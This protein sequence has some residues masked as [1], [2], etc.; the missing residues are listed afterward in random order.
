[1]V[2]RELLQNSGI[3]G[4]I[5]HFFS[6]NFFLS[7]F[8][9]IYIVDF[10]DDA[11]ASSVE[12]IFVTE[13]SKQIGNINLSSKCVRIIFKNNGFVFRSEDWNR[14]KKIAEGNPDEQKVCLH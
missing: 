12:I 14:L 9:I 13:K 4:C 3:F 2:Y 11:K 6:K 1:M 5:Y 7:T 8:I 10:L